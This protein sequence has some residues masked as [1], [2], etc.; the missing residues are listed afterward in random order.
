MAKKWYPVVDILTCME[1]GTCVSGCPHSVYDKTKAP[2]RRLYGRMPVSITAIT[3]AI[4]V[5][6]AQLLMLAMILAGFRRS[7]EKRE[8]CPLQHR[9]ADVDA[10]LEENVSGQ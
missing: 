4:S 2:L 3:A 10:A 1:C 7:C 5:L 8:T 9:I 6:P